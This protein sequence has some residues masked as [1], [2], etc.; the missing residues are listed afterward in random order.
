MQ[1]D[2]DGDGIGD[3]ATVAVTTKPKHKIVVLVSIGDRQGG[4][5]VIQQVPR[6]G[7]TLVARGL[8]CALPYP[9]NADQPCRLLFGAFA[10]EAEEVPIRKASK[11]T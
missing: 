6:T 5:T 1:G 3:V 2:F 7:N 10:S 8:F 11:G 4:K 9:A